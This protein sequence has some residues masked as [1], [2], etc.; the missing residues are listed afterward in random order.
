MGCVSFLSCGRW[1]KLN[2]LC[3]LRLRPLNI[4]ESAEIENFCE[5]LVIDLSTHVELLSK[6]EQELREL[7]VLFRVFLLLYTNESGLHKVERG[8]FLSASRH[9]HYVVD[10]ICSWL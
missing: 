7:F 3:R 9:A 6:G 4:R 8:I 2:E 10:S 5:R 1:I